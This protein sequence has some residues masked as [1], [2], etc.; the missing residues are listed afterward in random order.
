MLNFIF[1]FFFKRFRSRLISR[2]MKDFFLPN[3]KI[4]G[5][6]LEDVSIAVADNGQS[7]YKGTTRKRIFP[8]DINRKHDNRKISVVSEC[9]DLYRNHPAITRLRTLACHSIGLFRRRKERI[10]KGIEYW[11][12]SPLSHKLTAIEGSIAKACSGVK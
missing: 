9:A 4:V 2:S 3:F 8:S 1:I 12:L 6:E 10:L 5:K 7:E 11:K